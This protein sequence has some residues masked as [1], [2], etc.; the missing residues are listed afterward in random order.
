MKTDNYIWRRKYVHFWEFYSKRY[1][2]AKSILNMMVTFSYKTHFGDF[3]DNSYMWIH[4]VNTKTQARNSRLQDGAGSEKMYVSLKESL[5]IKSQF[6][7][8]SLHKN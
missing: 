3:D 6:F 1:T 5:F 7:V 8:K 2:F 4:A